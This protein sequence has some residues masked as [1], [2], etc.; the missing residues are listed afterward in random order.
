MSPI[1]NHSFHNALHRKEQSIPPIWMMRQAGRYHSHYQQ[2][3]QKY[4]FEQLCREPDLA[5]EVTL[6]PIQEFDFDAA[7]LFS[8]IL[9]PLESLGMDLTY[10]PGPIFGSHLNETNL[11]ELIT[12]KNAIAS[13]EFQGEAIERTRERLP[14]DKSL[15]GFIGGPWTLI[16]YA[17]GLSKATDT[18]SLDSFKLSFLEES[19]LP[20]LEKNIELQLKAG[21][22]N[23]MIFDSLAHQLARD[24]L[25]IYLKKVF[26][27][28]KFNLYCFFS[29]K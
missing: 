7:I 28:I 10:N 15:I 25:S 2:L 9:F 22:E 13:L 18:L 24:D 8:D 21:A 4:T 6:G 3:K 19:I 14:E 12:N 26:S 20:L 23:L 5:C 11:N 1:Y 27:S 17:C 29:F 16:S